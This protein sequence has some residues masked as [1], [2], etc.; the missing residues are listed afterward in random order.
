[1][2]WATFVAFWPNVLVDC[3]PHSANKQIPSCALSSE[4]LSLCEIYHYRSVYLLPNSNN[5]KI[6]C[7][8][9]PSVWF[10]RSQPTTPVTST[11]MSHILGMSHHHPSN[12]SWI[13][14]GNN[15]LSWEILLSL[16]MC[17]CVCVWH[18]E[19]KTTIWANNQS[20]QQ[21]Q[22]QQVKLFVNLNICCLIIF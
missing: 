9:L 21:Q 12:S 1:M 6:S 7:T 3:V 19:G 2:C 18:S 15:I 5:N 8:C 16:A 22:D 10:R 20:N 13:C 11:I 17:A 4:C 14:F